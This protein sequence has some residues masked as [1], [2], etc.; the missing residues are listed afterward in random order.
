MHILRF[1]FLL[2]LFTFVH[3]AFAQ[4]KEKPLNFIVIFADDLGY[5]DLSSFGHPTIQTP[6][7][8]QMV[9]Q[10]QKWT[11]FYVGASV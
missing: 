3:S 1:F 10:G 8:D 11:Q 7:L 2:P 5:G 9:V 6:N 4:N